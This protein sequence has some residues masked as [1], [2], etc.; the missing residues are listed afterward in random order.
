MKVRA[1]RLKKDRRP[2]RGLVHVSGGVKRWHGHTGRHTAAPI[3]V[4]ESGNEK[5]SAPVFGNQDAIAQRSSPGLASNRST[6][7][8]LNP[9]PR[10]LHQMRTDASVTIRPPI[11][12][13]AQGV[14][15]HLS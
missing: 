6:V 5:R 14:K 4:S 7:K 1:R 13:R 2:V 8:P 11:P 3:W 12:T 15:P 10:H 9:P